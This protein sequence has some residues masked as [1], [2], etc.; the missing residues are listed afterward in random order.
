MR[1]PAGAPPPAVAREDL[2]ELE[3]PLELQELEPLELQ[4]LQELLELLELQELQGP[5]ELQEA[6]ARSSSAVARRGA[7]RP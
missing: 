5:L 7:P 1:T 3:E 6:P 2:P 4:E